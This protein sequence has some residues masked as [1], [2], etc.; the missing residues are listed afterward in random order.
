MATTK[1]QTFP[2]D[3][4]VTSNFTVDTSTLRVDA[5][6]NNVG[7]GIA[8][9]TSDLHVAGN[10]GIGSSFY[11]GDGASSNLHA[12]PA[13]GKV[14]F[15]QATGS[16]KF[17]VKAD[18]D[19][20]AI[21][22]K[23]RVGYMD[24]E[25]DYAAWGHID[26]TGTNQWGLIQSASGTTIINTKNRIDIRENNTPKAY[27]T[28]SSATDAKLGIGRT[29]TYT[30][31]VDGLIKYDIMYGT[32]WPVSETMSSGLAMSLDTPASSNEVTY[33]STNKALVAPVKG[34]YEVYANWCGRI[35]NGGSIR[36]WT[37]TLRKNGSEIPAVGGT[38]TFTGSTQGW[39]QYDSN[40]GDYQ[41]NIL[42]YT[43]EL[44]ADDEIGW[45]CGTAF[46]DQTYGESGSR[47]SNIFMYLVQ[48]LP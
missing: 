16:N 7:V 33:N 32:V 37:I 36:G 3:L 19:V 28:G 35:N 23:C 30:I 21:V 11:V 27:I 34:L 25:T 8:S 13:T 14:G 18:T 47:R 44:D 5:I 10:V 15:G 17:E 12:D 26:S 41:Q 43:L 9:P 46:P 2:G 1:I 45:K 39:R 4:E 42:C 40:G 24:N 20:T 31:D 48:P 38:P 6:N 22:G 29:P